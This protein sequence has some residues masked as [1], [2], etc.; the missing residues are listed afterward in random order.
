M[1]PNN[2]WVR[3]AGEMVLGE[4]P[5][6]GRPTN[7]HYSRVRASALAV[8]ASGGCLDIFLS[9]IISHFSLLLSGRRS[10]I[11]RNTAI[12]A[13]KLKTTNQTIFSGKRYYFKIPASEILRVD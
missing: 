10:N 8:G 12:R 9:S 5:V 3:S 7:L 13:V 2:I 1:S 4:L 11:D 6:P